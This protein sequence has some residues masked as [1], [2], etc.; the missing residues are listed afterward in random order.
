M[1][2]FSLERKRLTITQNE[3]MLLTCT[4]MQIRHVDNWMSMVE[5][6]LQNDLHGHVFAFHISR[7]HRTFSMIGG[8]SRQVRLGSPL[9]MP[10][11]SVDLGFRSFDR[12]VKNGL[13]GFWEKSLVRLPIPPCPYC[14][15]REGG[16]KKFLIVCWN[17]EIHVSWTLWSNM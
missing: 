3:L 17:T 13:A 9:C 15:A 10:S 11:A 8:K 7:Q 6:D 5:K 1:C 14:R 12:N 16:K 2:L 4:W